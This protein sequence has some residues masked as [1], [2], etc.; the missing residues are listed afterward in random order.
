MDLQALE[1]R[2]DGLQAVEVAL[3]AVA[4][5]LDLALAALADALLDVSLGALGLELGEVLLD[6]GQAGVH[7]VVTTGLELLALDLDL[8]LQGR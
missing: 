1:P 6:L 3:R 2:P 7:V 4:Q 5:L 8:G